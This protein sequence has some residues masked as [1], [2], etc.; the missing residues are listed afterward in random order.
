MRPLVGGLLPFVVQAV[1]TGDASKTWSTEIGLPGDFARGSMLE[2]A[3]N[4]MAVL[5]EPNVTGGEQ[6]PK[7]LGDG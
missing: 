6:R 7:A 3:S 4:M 5:L 2:V 1:R